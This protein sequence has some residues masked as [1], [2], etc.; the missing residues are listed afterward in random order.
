MNR[1]RVAKKLLPA[2][3]LCACAALGFTLVT[4][5][6]RAEIRRHIEQ[7]ENDLN[8]HRGD[9]AEA[10][11]KAALRLDPQNE[12]LHELLGQYAMLN[13]KWLEGVAEFDW[14]HKHGSKK[15]HILCRQAACALRAEDFAVKKTAHLLAESELERDPDCV[16]A[17]GM[18]TTATSQEPF[19]QHKKQMDRLQRLVKQLPNDVDVLR[20]YAEELLE[21]YQYDELEKVVA[22]I[23]QLAPNDV[24]SY[25]LRG[26][27]RLGRPD[28]TS[29]SQA[30]ADFRTSLRLAPVNG[31]ARFGLGRAY[32]RQGKAREAVV[33]LEE[34]LRLQPG[35][36]RTY[37]ELER[38]YR[39]AGLKKE[40]DDAEAH[41]RVGQRREDAERTLLARISTHPENADYARRMGLILAE[42]GEIVKALVY[43]QRA[44]QL[45]PGDKALQ[46]TIRE[47]TAR[48]Q[49]TDPANLLPLPKEASMAQ[50]P[51]SSQGTGH[52]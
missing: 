33:Q 52:P 40:A 18:L 51:L 13:G 10:E 35:A 8:Q 28:P 9:E 44:D 31:G 36:T 24:G 25:N 50:A 4:Q 20:M 11:W 14:L 21:L 2:I 32:L 16:A 23:L 46:A 26:F 12:D 47:L 5:S 27:A 39:L 7:A 45:Q 22:H 17:L 1:I 42:S 37:F 49:G 38:A 43:L 34:T 29:V 15:K 30:V 6:R 48:L 19:Y 3:A 41:F